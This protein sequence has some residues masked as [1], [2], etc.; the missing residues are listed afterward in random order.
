MTVSAEFERAFRLH[1]QGKLRE[2]FLRYDAIVQADPTHAPALHF[3]GVVLHQ[4]GKHAEAIARIRAS[5]GIDPG[6][7]DAWSNLALALEAVD[8]R[9]A[10]INAL[11][12]AARLAPKSPEIWTNLAASELA[13]LLPL[14]DEDELRVDARV[15]DA[16][17]RVEERREA[18]SADQRPRSTPRDSWARTCA[19][20]R[21]SASGKGSCRSV[22]A[23]AAWQASWAMPAPMVPAPTTPMTEG[24]EETGPAAPALPPSVLRSSGCMETAPRVGRVRRER[25]R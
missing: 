17:G 23:P 25:A 11:K 1:Q 21:S 4:A 3:S 6:S 7:P 16:A 18:R 24:A 10:A 8:R 2:A 13:L 9:E 12:E 20:P 14:A 15:E 22:R 19:T 5:I